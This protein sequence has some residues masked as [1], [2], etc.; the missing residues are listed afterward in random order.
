MRWLSILGVVLILVGI[1]ALVVDYIPIHHREEVAKI[2]PLTATA[3]KETDV[4]IPPYA[5]VIVIVVGAA[6]VFA[7][8]GRHRA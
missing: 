4:V 6:L 7:G 2:G 5:G 8:R 1:A 3:D